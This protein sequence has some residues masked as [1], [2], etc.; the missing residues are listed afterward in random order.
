[1]GTFSTVQRSPVQTDHA[2]HDGIVLGKS[3][4]ETVRASTVMFKITFIDCR[5]VG[6]H[7]H[8][9]STG[10]GFEKVKPKNPLWEPARSPGVICRKAG[11]RLDA[12]QDG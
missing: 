6:V 10:L 11:L 9:V 7:C 8:P 5:T 1:M 3:L 4:N 12:G 2:D